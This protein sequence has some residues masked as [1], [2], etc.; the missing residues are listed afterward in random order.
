[1]IEVCTSSPLFVNGGAK[2]HIKS[3]IENKKMIKIY[4]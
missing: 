4:F 2:E 1:M 3:Q